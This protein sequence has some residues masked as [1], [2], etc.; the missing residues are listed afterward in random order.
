MREWLYEGIDGGERRKT[1][2]LI[3]SLIKLWKEL[4]KIKK[5]KNLN[6]S[7]TLDF[8]PSAS[9]A[10]EGITIVSVRLFVRDLIIF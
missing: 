7:Y 6:C 1:K 3:K 2:S 10:R 5:K 4:W 9:K 8:Y